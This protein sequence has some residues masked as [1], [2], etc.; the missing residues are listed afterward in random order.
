MA[1]RKL[2]FF[3]SL[4]RKRQRQGLRNLEV[5][6]FTVVDEDI[7]DEYNAEAWAFHADNIWV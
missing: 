5:P 6:E 7:I 4:I 2:Y 3:Q 1:A